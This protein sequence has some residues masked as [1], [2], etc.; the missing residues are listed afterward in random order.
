MTTPSLYPWSNPASSTLGAKA[1]RAFGFTEV[2]EYADENGARG[3][4]YEAVTPDGSDHVV[5]LRQRA[6][7]WHVFYL[8][9]ATGS[10]QDPVRAMT[11]GLGDA[12]YDDNDLRRYCDL[13][14]RAPDE[15]ARRFD[16]LYEAQ[17]QCYNERSR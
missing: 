5:L 8:F 4:W 15:L 17:S 3:Y 7:A 1:L 10:G 6:N 9:R 12:I 13:V 16:G 2:K 14:L 11:G